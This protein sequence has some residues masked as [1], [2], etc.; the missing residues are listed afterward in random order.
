MG[1][2]FL[3]EVVKKNNKSCNIPNCCQMRLVYGT[4]GIN[5]TEKSYMTSNMT[6]AMKTP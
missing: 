1:G 3:G 6:T 4:T 2:I 5:W